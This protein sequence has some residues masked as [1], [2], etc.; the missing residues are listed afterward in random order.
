MASSPNGPPGSHPHADRP[1]RRLAEAPDEYL[2]NCDEGLEEYSERRAA[3]LWGVPR[4]ELQRWK[5]M[6]DLP[7]ELF[8]RLL[9]GGV[10]STK[11]MAQVA[12]ALQR[13]AMR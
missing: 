4:I 10:R 1:N 7:E 13:G 12:L 3:K 2:R 5:L 11:A 9:A 8:E 6:A